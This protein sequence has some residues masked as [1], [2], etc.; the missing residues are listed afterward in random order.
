MSTRTVVVLP[1]VPVMWIAGNSS[2]GEPRYCISVEIRS[3]VGGPRRLPAGTLRLSRLTCELS[4]PGPSKPVG[5]AHCVGLRELDPRPRTAA[6]A[7][8]SSLAIL[9]ASH[10][11]ARAASSAASR[12]GGVDHA[13]P[14]RPATASDTFCVDFT[15]RTSASTSA[16][17]WYTSGSPPSIAAASAAR[18]ATARGGSSRRATTTTLLR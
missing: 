18:P 12:S 15:L 8:T 10:T 17:T 3:S 13:R 16:A 6:P 11:S 1:F 4:Q 9:P 2:S 5:S 14:A 7:S